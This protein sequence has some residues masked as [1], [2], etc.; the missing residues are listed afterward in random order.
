LMRTV[1]QLLTDNGGIDVW[2]KEFKRRPDAPEW[3]QTQMAG[4][5]AA[6]PLADVHIPAKPKSKPDPVKTQICEFTKAQMAKY[7]DSDFEVYYNPKT[8]AAAYNASDGASSKE[9]KD[10][11]NGLTAAGT[12]K[13]KIFNEDSPN[14]IDWEQIDKDDLPPSPKNP[15]PGMEI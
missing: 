11:R 5:Y 6:E 1:I 15:T 9:L 10:A 14:G 7:P 3:Q 12:S 4:Y 8:Q 2:Q 13:V